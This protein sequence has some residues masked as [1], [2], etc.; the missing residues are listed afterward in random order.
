MF[1][2]FYWYRPCSIYPENVSLN[3][4][5]A[6]RRQNQTTKKRSMITSINQRNFGHKLK[7]FFLENHNQWQ[8]FQLINVLVW[9]YLVAFRVQWH[10]SWKNPLNYLQ[11][12]PGVILQNLHQKLRKLLDFHIFQYS[13]ICAKRVKIVISPEI[14]RYWQLTSWA[15]ERL[16]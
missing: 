15:I 2:V 14:H 5:K 16:W 1:T 11:I 9:T 4:F 12:L 13:I 10:Q 8:T 7:T 3:H 6:L